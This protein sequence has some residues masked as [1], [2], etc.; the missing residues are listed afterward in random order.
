MHLIPNTHT[1]PFIGFFTFVTLKIV[2]LHKSTS[3]SPIT[4]PTRTL[5]KSIKILTANHYVPFAHK[6][7]KVVAVL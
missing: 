2:D 7:L 3:F 4:P 6:L 1:V 5:R